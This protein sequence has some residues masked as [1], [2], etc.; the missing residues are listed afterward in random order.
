VWHIL[1]NVESEN[2]IYSGFLYHT[3][4]YAFVQVE[5]FWFWKTKGDVLL[6]RLLLF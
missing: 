1:D 3:C 6:Q 2:K 5:S 4:L